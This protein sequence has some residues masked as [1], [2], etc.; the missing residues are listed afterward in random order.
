MAVLEVVEDGN[1]DISGLIDL[2]VDLLMTPGM[3]L[4]GGMSTMGTAI[5]IT[6]RYFYLD[7]GFV[8]RDWW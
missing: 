5:L 3:S 4:L 1:V 2:E 6:S 8:K 7:M